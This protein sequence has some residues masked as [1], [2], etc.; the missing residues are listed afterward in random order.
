MPPSPRRRTT[1]YRWLM[2]RSGLSGIGAAAIVHKSWEPCPGRPRK[3]ADLKGAEKLGRPPG[4]WR[5]NT[6]N[7]L[8]TQSFSSRQ[9]CQKSGDPTQF[10]GMLRRPVNRWY[11]EPSGSPLRRDDFTSYMRASATAL[12]ASNDLTSSGNGDEPMRTERS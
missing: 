11:P 12:S 3:K 7:P 4:R 10:T 9:E 2:R 1:A 8:K 6:T 5:E